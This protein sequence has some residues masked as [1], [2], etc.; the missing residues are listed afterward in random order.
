MCSCCT[1]KKACAPIEFCISANVN[2][3]HELLP[4][5]SLREIS[6]SYQISNTYN[7]GQTRC[8]NKSQK[9]SDQTF[10]WEIYFII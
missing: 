1:R 5:V 8:L 10:G 6:F 9:L 3:L 4:I 2:V 7:I